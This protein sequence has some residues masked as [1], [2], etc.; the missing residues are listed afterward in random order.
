MEILP[1]VLLG[2]A[3]ILAASYM[4]LS[5]RPMLPPQEPVP[6][7]EVPP[8][9]PPWERIEKP[10]IPSHDLGNGWRTMG[11]VQTLWGNDGPVLTRRSDTGGYASIPPEGWA[12][13]QNNFPRDTWEAFVNIAFLESGFSLDAHATGIEDSMGPWQVNR[14]AWPQYSPE[15]LR[16]WEGNASAAAAIYEIQGFDAWWNAS[17]MLG[18]R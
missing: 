17:G 7:G 18:L 13:V 4:R 12:A 15:R 16:T 14:W 2:F 9:P 1:I 6:M 10:R 5:K 11:I 8:P 3:V